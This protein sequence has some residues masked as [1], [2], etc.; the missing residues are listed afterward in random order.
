MKETKKGEDLLGC[1]VLILMMVQA[2]TSESMG[3]GEKV[4]VRCSDKKM[5]NGQKIPVVHAHLSKVC[6]DIQNFQFRTAPLVLMLRHAIGDDNL[7]Q[8]AGIDAFDGVTAEHTMREKC[9]DFRG[10]LFLQQLGRTCN[11]IGGIGKVVYQDGRSV[12]YIANEHHD[13]ILPVGDARGAAFLK[14]FVDI[15]SL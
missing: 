7:V 12:G 13:G 4:T 5:L 15:W 10:T 2:M 1:G 6:A 14:S 8:G 3:G 11:G 9:V